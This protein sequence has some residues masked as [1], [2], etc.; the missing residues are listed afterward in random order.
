M[1]KQ[2][3]ELY[4]GAYIDNNDGAYS[5]IDI[6]Q[7]MRQ[8]ALQFGV[9]KS[10]LPTEEECSFAGD[11]LEHHNEIHR[12]LEE[13]LNEYCTTDLTCWAWNEYTFGLWYTWV[14]NEELA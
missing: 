8:I 11:F 6:S 9:P 2:H 12:E 13:L 1:D 5:P 10:K 14:V 4:I 3:I 7:K